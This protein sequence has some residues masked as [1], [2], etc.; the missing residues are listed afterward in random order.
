MPELIRAYIVVLLM[1]TAVLF[2]IKQA[3]ILPIQGRQYNHLS[4]YW[5]VAT[6]FAYLSH[7]YWIFVSGL[8]AMYLIAIPKEIHRRLPIYFLVLPALPLLKNEV[9]F[10]GGFNYL[11]L[12]TVPR[13]L[14]ICIL[15]PIA[16]HLIRTRN[17]RH[18]SFIRTDMIAY[19][20]F[21]L[22][23]LL[24][25]RNTT[26]TNGIRTAFYVFLDQFLPYYVISRSIVS[27]DHFKN[28]FSA[29]LTST[30]VLSGIS[31]FEFIKG[32]LLYNSLFIIYGLDKGQSPYQHRFELLRINATF[33]GPIFLG[34]FFNIGLGTLLFLRTYIIKISTY[35]FLIAIIM[36]ALLAT[37]SRGAWVGT[38]ILIVTFITLRPRIGIN[39]VSF[40]MM[41]TFCFVLLLMIPGGD[42]FL[43]YLPFVG[44]T[45][46]HTISYRQDLLVNGLKVVLRN[47]WFGSADNAAAP[48]L[49]AM[50]QGQGIID[51]VNTYLQISLRLGFIGLSLFLGIFSSLLLNIRKQ[52]IRARV[53]G[54]EYVRLGQ[55][56]FAIIFAVLVII[57]TVSMIDF[58]PIYYWALAGLGVAYI[59]M[60]KAELNK[61]MENQSI[62]V[63]IVQDGGKT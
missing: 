62:A 17:T 54:N 39:V 20:F 3:R 21:I 37:L 49:E 52:M 1:S 53:L 7:N 18:A 42:A 36:I 6:S 10:M 8:M 5:I 22:V 12:L 41:G 43:S 24:S 63:G 59:N 48:E 15:L 58:V 14:A 40:L 11:F 32:W 55:A 57:A 26:L 34:Y 30:L 45:I 50:R 61:L 4:A 31:I 29:I 2:L 27:L 44:D 60:I 38:I 46:Q 25:F 9:P 16:I 33:H 19:A 28:I 23:A 56:L 51:M 35:Y 47:P 13:L